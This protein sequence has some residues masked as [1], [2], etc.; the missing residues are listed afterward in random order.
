MTT[1]GNRLGR[2]TSPYLQQHRNNP[3][4]WWPWGEAALAEAARL[5]RPILL[6]VGYAACHWCHVMAHESFED[7]EIAQLMNQLF[8]NIKVDREER[9]DV[10]MVYQSALAMLGQQGGW[11][12]TMFLTPAA[13][14]FWGGTYFPPNQSYGR[15]AFPDVLQQVAAIF[16]DQP[17]KV[18]KNVT[19][20]REGL[21]KLSSP[22]SGSGLTPAMAEDVAAAALRLVDP[23]RGGT[24]GAPKFPQPTFIRHLWRAYRQTRATMFREGVL[25]TLDA[26]CQGGIYDHLA[27]GFARYSTD[28]NWLVPHFE[29][30]LYDNALLVDLLTEV[31]LAT[32]S[33]L[34]AQR[35]DETIAWLLADLRVNDPASG[36]AAFA[37]AFDADSEGEEGRYYVWNQEAI[38]AILADDAPAFCDAYAVSP[39]GNWEGRNILHRRRDAGDDAPALATFLAQCRARLLGRRRERVPPLRDDKVL[40]D[41][42]GLT[43]EAIARAAIAFDRPEWL[44][45]ALSAYRFVTEAMRADD[46]LFHSWCGG[47][48]AHPGVLEDYANMARAALTLFEVTGEAACLAQARTWVDTLDRYYWDSEGSGY[49]VAASDTADLLVRPKSIADHAVPSGNG[50][51]VEV[52]A[53][54]YFLTGDASTLQRAEQLT[55]LFSGQNQQYLLGIPGLFTAYAWLSQPVSQVIILGAATDPAT[56]LLSQAALTAPNPLKTV[57]TIADSSTLPATHPAAGKTLV[58]GRPTAYVCVGQRCGLPLHEAAALRDALTLT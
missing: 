16:R 42:N 56:R 34:Y 29:K 15:P 19:A 50:V 13:E 1:V 2:E 24:A 8:I 52:L 33:P 3:V 47:R 31:W 18:T 53:R 6:S 28:V 46:R 36:T 43:I 5:D 22:P 20:L 21:D 45:A 54:L 17:D 41:W 14:P 9:P 44:D 25:L 10:D 40:A 4:H 12:L 51:M 37:S 57:Q 26:I 48:A 27:G 32:G 55:T 35:V 49:F 23:I 38:E 11:P 7:P 58:D 39:G 30:M